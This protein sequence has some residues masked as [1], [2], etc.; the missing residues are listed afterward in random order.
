MA[1]TRDGFTLDARFYTDDS[2]IGTWLTEELVDRVFLAPLAEDGILDDC[3]YVS[4]NF[5]PPRP[6]GS[7]D[8]LR[9]Q[10]RTWRYE[11]ID[12]RSEEDDLDPG[13]EVILRFNTDMV[14]AS[15]YL[16]REPLARV[17]DRLVSLAARW[18]AQWS[19]ALPDTVDLSEGWLATERGDYPRPRPPRS[20]QWRLDAV[21][22]YFGQR[23]MRRT[24]K[25]ALLDGLLR[26]PLAPGASRELDGDAVLLAFAGDLRDEA[27]VA[28]ARAAHEQWI[29]RIVPTEPARGWNAEGDRL[30]VPAGAQPLA[31]LTL[32]DPDT[33]VG[34]KAIVVQ[35]DGSVD[36]EIWAELLAILQRGA[37]PDGAP[38]ASIRLIVPV[39]DNALALHDRAIAAGFE[40][41]TYPRGQGVFWQ[42]HPA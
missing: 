32:Y 21:S 22:H 9:A 12:L 4:S 33:K 16:V 3:R 24:G 20:S 18:V 29:S 11:L 41:V 30:V 10:S 31:P 27:A 17:A 14:N 34:Y 35:P 1:Y 40:M 37:L 38:L 23:W 19:R 39:R 15:V 6:I 5:K 26:E 8:E 28:R 42:V 36:E 7:V 25:G 13:C 2:V